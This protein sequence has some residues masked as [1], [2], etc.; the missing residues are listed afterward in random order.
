L[1][2]YE[3]LYYSNVFYHR[4][5]HITERSPCE[6]TVGRQSDIGR[7]DIYWV[8]YEIKD[9]PLGVRAL[10]IR[11]ECIYMWPVSL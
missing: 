9:E 2:P 6:G 4:A 3:E 8:K 1:V 5:F 11:G 7:I 10:G